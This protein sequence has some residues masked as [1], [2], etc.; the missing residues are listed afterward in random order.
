M[1]RKLSLAAVAAATAVMAIPTAVDA[2]PNGRAYGYYNNSAQARYY[3][4][5]YGSSYGNDYYAN[6]GYNGGY[7]NDSYRYR[8][9]RCSGTTGTI[10]GGVAGALLGRAATRDYRHSGTTGT[11]LGGALGALAGNAVDKSSCRRR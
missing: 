2:H 3:N 1:I 4:Q 9:R 5:G 10:V 6:R 7:Y 8:S 11:I